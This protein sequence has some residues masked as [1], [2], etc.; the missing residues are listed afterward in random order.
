MDPL[1]AL[2]DGALGQPHGREG[3]ESVGEV[4]L[5]I[6]RAGLDAEHGGRSDARQHAVR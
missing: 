3:G 1:P 5:D 4:D 6:H 2:L